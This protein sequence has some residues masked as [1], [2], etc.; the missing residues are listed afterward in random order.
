MKWLF[1]P[2]E[3]SFSKDKFDCGISE[4]NEY[5]LKYALQNQKTGVAKTFV[6]IA[7]QEEKIIDG[8]YSVSMSQIERATIPH[9]QAKRLPRYPIPAMLIGKLAVDRKSQGQGLGEELLIDALQKAVRL[10]GEIGIFAVRVDA[11]NDRAKSF[12]LKYGFIPLKDND[13]ALFLPMKTIIKIFV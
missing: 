3:R 1:L 12:Y 7:N 10:A 9:E 8:Y 4:L 11:I 2:L 6:A 13:S 5:L